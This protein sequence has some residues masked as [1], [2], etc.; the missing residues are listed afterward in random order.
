MY[1]GNGTFRVIRL[2]MFWEQFD[3]S[4]EKLRERF[5]ESQR[6]ERDTTSRIFE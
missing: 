5:D 2:V 3:Y 1:H 4:R 6:Y